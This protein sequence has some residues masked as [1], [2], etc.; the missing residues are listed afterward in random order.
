MHCSILPL[1]ENE[2]LAQITDL[3]TL[4]PR[5]L[6]TPFSP[7]CAIGPVR[8]AVELTLEKLSCFLCLWTP[9][10]GNTWKT[11]THILGM[12]CLHRD[13]VSF[14]PLDILDGGPCWTEEMADA[15]WGAERMGR[16][17]GENESQPGGGALDHRLSASPWLRR[18]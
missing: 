11:C 17:L 7:T 4:R 8:T 14:K 15:V 1:G 2:W 12:L 9:V 6:P 13:I 10:L 3:S 16:P 18:P 5:V